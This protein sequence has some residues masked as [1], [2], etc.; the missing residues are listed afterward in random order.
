MSNKVDIKTYFRPGCRVHL[1]GIG[2]VSMCALAEALKG[3]GLSVQG[4]DM[5]AA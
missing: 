1:V 4:S 3:M 5:S 2:G